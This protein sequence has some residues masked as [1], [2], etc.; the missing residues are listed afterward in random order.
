MLPIGANSGQGIKAWAAVPTWP[1]SEKHTLGKD[2][3]SRDP[4]P[5]SP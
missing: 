2:P 1:L 3:M 4:H 5:F